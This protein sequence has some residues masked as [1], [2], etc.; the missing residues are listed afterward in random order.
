MTAELHGG[1]KVT[2]ARR[3][4]CRMHFVNPASSTIYEYKKAVLLTK[5]G[6]FC[7]IKTLV[8]LVSESNQRFRR[9]K[10][11]EPNSLK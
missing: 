5:G 2:A 3:A 6:L 8:G 1:N 11:I 4:K 9:P 7:F 10:S